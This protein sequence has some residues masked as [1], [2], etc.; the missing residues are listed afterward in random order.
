MQ[1]KSNF[2]LW[3]VVEGLWF[4]LQVSFFSVIYRHTESIAG[5]TK[6]EV[7]FLIGA[8]HFVQQLFTALFLTNLTQLSELIRTGKMDFMLLLPVN[9][10]FLVSLRQVDLGGFVN[11]ASAVGVMIFAAIQLHIVPTLAQVVGFLFLSAAGVLLHYSLMLILA[12]SSF[13]TVRAQGIVWGYYNL[14]NIA[15]MPDSAFRG[16]FKMVFTLFLPMLLVANVP[17]RLL[18]QK[19]SEPASIAMFLGI[20]LAWFGISEWIWRFSLRRYTSASS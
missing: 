1:F 2:L 3:I 20:A 9:T 15:R 4:A 8:S 10:R 19:A 17:S 12:S 13:F 11:A 7:I 14:F 16:L 5:W 6:Y 18:L